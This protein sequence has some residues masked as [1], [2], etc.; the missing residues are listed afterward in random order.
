MPA[1]SSV[2]DRPATVTSPLGKDVL[3]LFRM[4]AREELGRL[5]EFQLELLSKNPEIKLEDVLG[6]SM[7]VG[8]ALPEGNTRYF[9]GLCVRFS[10]TGRTGR[11][12]QYQATLRPWL[13]MLT[14]T[15]DCR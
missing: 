7:T 11:F 12:T 3:L 6:K 15:A 14:R 9:T 1:S 10:Q 5:A 8:L 13:W 2:T 4:T